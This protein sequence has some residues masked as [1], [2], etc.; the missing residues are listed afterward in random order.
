MADRRSRLG[1]DAADDSG[2][3]T[4]S[5]PL[6]GEGFHQQPS[7]S[8]KEETGPNEGGEVDLKTGKRRFWGLGKKK[9]EDKAKKKRDEDAA[10]PKSTPVSTDPDSQIGSIRPV[11]P[12]IALGNVAHLPK[13]SSSHPYTLPSSPNRNLNSSS[14]APPS[15]A[16]SQI[17][18]RHVQEDGLAAA[19]SPAIPN[20]ITTENH[21]PPV[22]DA[23]SA[24]I[25][26]DHLNPDNVEIITHAAHQPAAVTVTGASLSEAPGTSI[27]DDL[28]GHAENDETASNYGAL[29]STDVRRLSFISFADVVHAE[30]VD[31]G[32]SV[33]VGAISPAAA[34]NRSPSPARSPLAAQVLSGSPV[35]GSSVSSR[36]LE[37]SPTIAGRSLASP[38]PTHTS[39]ASGELTI[40]TMRQA[41][42]KTGSGDLSGAKSIPLSA[43]GAD[44][45]TIDSLK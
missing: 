13:S 33:A 37:I 16:S 45:S 29:D 31:Y 25:T 39:P 10:V 20:H 5:V 1:Q 23:S 40:E 27:Y 44:D 19:A 12:I 34:H 30:H 4:S 32:S 7:K 6:L 15:P 24:A 14:P 38:L 41:L 18:E 17:F 43:V 36:G 28:S 26:D 42:R 35:L 11:S 2:S 3:R 21:I 8:S 9:D 22:L